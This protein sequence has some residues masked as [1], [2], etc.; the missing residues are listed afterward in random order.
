MSIAG[1]LRRHEFRKSSQWFV[2]RRDHAQ[3]ALDE[4]PVYERFAKYCVP[5]WDK[6]YRRDRWCFSDEVSL[7]CLSMDALQ[8]T[9]S[10]AGTR[11]IA[12]TSGD[13]VLRVSL[14]APFVCLKLILHE[15][16]AICISVTVAVHC[17]IAGYMLTNSIGHVQKVHLM[18]AYIYELSACAADE[19]VELQMPGQC[20]TDWCSRIPSSYPNGKM[21][22]G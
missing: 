5:G 12:G 10:Q 19:A 20:L 13:V 2:L 7:R 22:N 18:W 3:L 11:A 14:W 15:L 4:V 16:S 21:S 17:K 9:A 1:G 8:S 6:D